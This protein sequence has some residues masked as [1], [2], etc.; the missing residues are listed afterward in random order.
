[1][2]IT[3]AIRTYAGSFA[4]GSAVLSFFLFSFL[5]AVRGKT[6]TKD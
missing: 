5:R 4:C 2:D 3:I 6:K 1:L